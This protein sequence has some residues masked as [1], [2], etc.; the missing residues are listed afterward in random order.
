MQTNFSINVDGQTFDLVSMNVTGPK[1]FQ[2]FA[3]VNGKRERFHLQG[4]GANPLRFCL[5][6]HV[7]QSLRVL[8]RG[9]SDEIFSAYRNAGD[10]K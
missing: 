6:E 9:I 2:L 5:P 7:P 1:L 10:I 4:D 8:E 3:I